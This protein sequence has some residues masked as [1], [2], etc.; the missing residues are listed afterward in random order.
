MGSVIQ[1]WFVLFLYR[2]NI[3]IG[4]TTEQMPKPA[5]C[6]IRETKRY[7]THRSTSLQPS[8]PR[9]PDR[10]QHRG[11]ATARPFIILELVRALGDAGVSRAAGREGESELGVTWHSQRTSAAGRP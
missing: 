6:G 7:S 1:R 11:L 4:I 9:C 2:R 10:H 5:R 3:T 8:S